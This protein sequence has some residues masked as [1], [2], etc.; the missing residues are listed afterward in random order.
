MVPIETKTTNAILKAPSGQEENVIGKSITFYFVEEDN[1]YSPRICSCWKLSEEELQQVQETGCI[2]FHTIGNSHPP[3]L[4]N[5]SGIEDM[6]N[7]KIIP[8]DAI[9]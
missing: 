7:V 3:I 8:K 4:L 2:Y 1:A 9:G 6:E 5:T